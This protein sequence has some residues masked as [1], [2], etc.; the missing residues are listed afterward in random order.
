MYT[1]TLPILIYACYVV[2]ENDEDLAYHS[3]V[4]SAEQE[5]GKDIEI[6]EDDKHIV[7]IEE[8]K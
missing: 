7:E 5:Y 6:L 4:K 3:A 1:V 2:S 8:A